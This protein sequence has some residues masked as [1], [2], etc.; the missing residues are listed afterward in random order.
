MQI[1]T[2]YPASLQEYVEYG[3]LG[4]AM[5]RYS[6]C[7]TAMKVTGETVETSGTVELDRENRE[8][9][10]PTADEFIMPPGGVHIRLGDVPRDIDWRLQNFKLFACHAFARK[11]KIDKTIMDSPKPR[12]G[13]ITAGKSYGDVRQA[14]IELGIDDKVAAEI[15]LRVYKVGKKSSSSKKNAN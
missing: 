9:L 10:T 12:F 14:L 5:S 6:G 13:I 15:G 11:N 4:I 2:L 7:W 3:L 8:I 1:P